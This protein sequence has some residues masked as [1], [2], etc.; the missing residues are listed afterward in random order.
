MRASG[1]FNGVRAKARKARTISIVAARKSGLT[2][3]RE[4][5]Q[6]QSHLREGIY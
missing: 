1:G 6:T 2:G 5:T 3:V 4:V